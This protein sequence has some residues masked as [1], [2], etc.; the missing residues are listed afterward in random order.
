MA[1]SVRFFQ[2]G[3]CRQSNAMSG[4]T[5]WQWRRYYAVFL[6]V[7]H[8]EQGN[9]LI[10]TGYSQDFFDATR[11]GMAFLSRLMLPATLD[12]HLD[13]AGI[14]NS[15]GVAPETIRSIF[16][17]HFHADH[18][19]GLKRF[20]NSRYIARRNAWSYLA[21][22]SSWG[23]S[24]ELFFPTLVPDDFEQRTD[25]IEEHEFADAHSSLPGFR[26]LDYWKDG[27][28]FLVDL[29]GHAIGQYGLFF[30]G[31]PRPLL[32]VVDAAWN[33]QA[34]RSGRQIPSPL[35]FLQHDAKAYRETWTALRS[36][37]SENK[38]DMI[39]CHCQETQ[40]RVENLGADHAH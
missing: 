3:Y 30:P 38:I 22:L 8:P 6:L 15:C 33:L 1:L 10:D 17:T 36:L 19:S 32:Y 35:M 13:A 12:Q 27:S 40:A 18:I 31:L 21:S 37:Q 39:A 7:S 14:L 34:M 9:V 4:G 25:W 20:P 23:K 29:P 5:G 11:W 26:L 28:M 24:Q 2:S 16:I